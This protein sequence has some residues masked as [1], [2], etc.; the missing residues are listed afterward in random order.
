VLD[1]SVDVIAAEVAEL[2]AVA[3]QNR[4]IAIGEEKHVAGVTQD[5]RY[6]G[7]NEVLALAQP[8]YDRRTLAGGNDFIWIATAKHGEREYSAQ[9]FDGL[10][11]RLLQIAVEIFLDEVRDDFGVGLRFED[12]TFGLELFLQREIVFDDPVVDDDDVAAAVGCAF[13]SVGRPCVAQRV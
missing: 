13:S 6:V 7:S 5:S 9:I 3:S 8:D 11:H 2:D 12:V 4:H 10:P 1:S